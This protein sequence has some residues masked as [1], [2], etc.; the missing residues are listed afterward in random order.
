M[1]QGPP[2]FLYFVVSHQQVCRFYRNS[3]AGEIAS[4]G[5]VIEKVVADL[6]SPLRGQYRH[7]V[8]IFG[9]Q[10]LTTIHIDLFQLVAVA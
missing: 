10:G 2:G 5:L 7:L 6:L 4:Q 1:P 9:G 8:A 3:V